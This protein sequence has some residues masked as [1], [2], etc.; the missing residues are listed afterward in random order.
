ML[1]EIS[2]VKFIFKTKSTR[3]IEMLFNYYSLP[4]NNISKADVK[5]AGDYS[6]LEID[7]QEWTDIDTGKSIEVVLT[8]LLKLTNPQSGRPGLSLAVA[9]CGHDNVKQVDFIFTS[10]FVKGRHCLIGYD[11]NDNEMLFDQQLS[12]TGNKID[13]AFLKLQEQW[14]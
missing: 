11:A 12:L 2:N 9:V 1:E 14:Q 5:V 10:D 3:N 6:Y 8:A 13:H 4:K 7:P